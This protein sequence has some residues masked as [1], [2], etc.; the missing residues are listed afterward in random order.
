MSSAEGGLPALPPPPPGAPNPPP[1]PWPPGMLIVVVANG[2][3]SGCVHDVSI[4]LAA[5]RS[6]RSGARSSL[7]VAVG[8][9]VGAGVLGVRVV[10]RVEV[11]GQPDF[12]E[13]QAELVVAEFV[14]R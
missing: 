1:P 9:E 14:E 2:L 4:C 13:R 11:V 12:G 6:L 3:F 8:V 7:H 5:T 10:D